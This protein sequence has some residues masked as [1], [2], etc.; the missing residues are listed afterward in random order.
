MWVDLLVWAAWLALG[1]LAF[2]T[3]L[4]LWRTGTWWVRVCDFPRLQITGLLA[5]PLALAA[6]HAGLAGWSAAHTT[7]VALAAVVAVWQ[8]AHVVRYS[9][10]WPT[11]VPDA[12]A[13]PA[14]RLLTANIDFENDRHDAVLDM[15]RAVDADV[16]LLIEVDEPAAEALA[17]LDEVYPRRVGVVRGEGLGLVM[18]SRLA[19]VDA[20]VRHLVSQRR[21]SVFATLDVPGMGAVRYVGLHPTPPGLR[22]RIAK[23]QA[24]ETRRDS[25]V[26]DA[27]LVLVAKEIQQADGRPWIVT[28]DFNDVAWSHTTRLFKR[29]SGLKDPRVGRKLLTT[30]HADRSVWRYPI[31]HLFFSPGFGLVSFDRRRT[32]GSD[33]FAITAALALAVDR[34][35]GPVPDGDGEDHEEA[36]EKVVE[37]VGDAA[38]HGVDSAEGRAAAAL[39]AARLTGAAAAPA[40]VR[41]P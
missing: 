21:A 35:V 18:W 14:V 1:W 12:D 32:P 38:D 10:L 5:V 33:H 36:A 6:A 2:C 8:L 31:D 34:P 37:G 23:Q 26:R 17:P 7:A 24:D 15:V 16:V 27:E 19:V 29:L 4:P 30:Y 39:A 25:R 3:V 20:E 11:E 22:N 40:A 28:G 9:P 13:A 41:R